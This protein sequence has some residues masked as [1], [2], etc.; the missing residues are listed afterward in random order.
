[1]RSIYRKIDGVWQWF[2]ADGTPTESVAPAV[3]QDTMPRLRH[4]VT[5]HIYESK[6]AYMRATNRLGLTVVGNDLL[7]KR[8]NTPT[9]IV[10]EERV[11]EAIQK[12]ESILS[13]PAKRN[14]LKYKNQ[15]L[16]E[17]YNKRIRRNE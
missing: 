12:S 11:L 4:P 17:E 15:R 1:M 8:K 10:T 13:D 16:L 9:D 6:S 14:E 7:S 2:E 3:H 5:G